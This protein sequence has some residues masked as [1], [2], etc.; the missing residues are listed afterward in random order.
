MY[1]N[2]LYIWTFMETILFYIFLLVCAGL[3]KSRYSARKTVL[4]LFLGTTWSII[5]NAVIFF[6]SHDVAFT[7]NF[8]PLTAYIPAI[9]VLH[10]LSD[11][12]FFETVLI[13]CMGLLGMYA[14]RF[15]VKTEIYAL[16]HTNIPTYAHTGIR[17]LSL[18]VLLYITSMTAIRYIRKPF[19]QYIRCSNRNWIMPLTLI[20]LL[21]ISFSYVSHSTFNP[22]ITF[23]LFLTAITTFLL[24]GKLFQTEY[25]RTELKKEQNE[26]EIRIRMQQQECREISQK[27]ELL[28]E[29]RH[30][31]RHHLLALSG[32]LQN[33]DNAHAEEYIKSLVER[34][35][36]T[37]NVIYCENQIINAVLSS[38]ITK[39]KK[40]GCT[41][42]TQISIP[43]KLHIKDVDLCVILSNA[44]ENAVHA[45][46]K[47]EEGCRRLKIKIDMHNA[48]RINIKNCCKKAV[49]FD[50]DGLPITTSTQNHGMG[51]KSI[52]RTV[53]KYNGIFKCAYADDEFTLNILLFNVPEE[54]LS[55]NIRKNRKPASTA[56]FSVLALCLFLTSLPV[57][58]E[59]LSNIPGFRSLTQVITTKQHR[60]G[61]GESRFYAEEPK[62][63][64]DDFSM[65]SQ[66][67][68]AKTAETET[69][70][71]ETTQAIIPSEAD[72]E[73]GTASTAESSSQNEAASF[74]GSSDRNEMTPSYE[75]DQTE[76]I[77][78]ISADST[79]LEDSAML[80]A[81]QI[82]MTIQPS[83][84]SNAT[85]G[86]AVTEDVVEDMNAKMNEY[87]ETLRKTYNWY[88]QHKY[89]GYVALETTYTILCNNDTM[90][91]IRFD[92]TLN[93]GSS[94]DFSCCFTLDKRTGTV[95]AL[96]D[97]FQENS[98]YI[99]RISN[100]IL[101]EMTAQNKN[102]TA[103]FFIPGGIWLDDECFKNISEEQNFYINEQGKLV[104]LFAECEVAPA[105]MGC[106][107][108]VIPTDAIAA[109]LAEPSLIQ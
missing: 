42:D 39:A 70:L 35:E 92:G 53:T 43:E 22:F 65:F 82:H 97:L 86:N 55:L 45:C 99:A 91:S 41:L 74:S 32:I 13:W 100:S 21:L 77:S 57:A 67:S 58:T 103:N 66:N 23:L 72:S 102:G 62:V 2:Y 75:P 3:V 64:L 44:L 95:I 79:V 27:H 50:S 37:E 81:T 30:D 54:E 73:N 36:D 101:D 38:Y 20:L 98:D 87:I 105:S 47:E 5:L 52:V 63:L 40:I 19:R 78:I 31:M 9:L 4:L 15:L 71:P 33:S 14:G 96:K 11:N 76:S 51:I 24:I 108:F 7:L 48:L 90:L 93:A 16:P 18:L 17:F 29:Y 26:Y 49:V 28:R 46:E 69:N 88:V 89:M 25:A 94:E 83:I 85:T 106:V 1:N 60:T 56:L 84:F 104:I 68:L 80:G 34:L 59:A 109:I 10:L 107:E 6:W 12:G 61:W 8:L